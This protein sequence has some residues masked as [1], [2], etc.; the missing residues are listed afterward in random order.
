MKDEWSKVK[1]KEPEMMSKK[2]FI[3]ISLML[4]LGASLFGQHNEEVTIEGTYRPKVNKV[5]KILITPVAPKPSFSMPSTEV[6]PMEINHQFAV[7]LEK[8]PPLALHAKDAQNEHPTKNFLMV[9]LGTRISPVFL[10]KHHSKLTRDLALGVGIRHSSSWLGIKDYGPSGFMNNAFDISLT[11]SKFKNVQ[12]GGDV[13]YHNDLYHFYGFHPTTADM[14]ALADTTR[15]TYNTIGTHLGIAS[16]TTRLGE[17]SHNGDLDY[18]FLFDRFDGREHYAG[19]DYEL[20]YTQRWWGDKNYP[21][22]VGVRMDFKYA[23]FQGYLFEVQ[24][25]TVHNSLNRL[26]FQVNPYFEMKDEFYRLHL[27]FLADVENTKPLFGIYPDLKGSLFVLNKKV[28]FYAGLNGGKKFLTYSQLME[29]NPFL[30][31]EVS[32]IATPKV[33]LGFEAGIRTNV[34][35]TLDIHLGVRYRHTDNDM[36]F[37]SSNNTSSANPLGVN[38]CFDIVLDEARLLSVLANVRWLALDKLTL[39]AG[40]AYNNYTM[41]SLA[42]PWYRP[43]TEGSLKATYA[44]DDRLSMNAAFLYQGGRWGT[45]ALSSNQPVKLK[46]VFYLAL[47]ADYKIQDQLTVFAKLDNVAH[48]K[49][50]VFYE[51]PVAGI[52]FFAGVKMRF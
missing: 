42:H 14:A 34:M 30:G 2:Q 35:E 48:Q 20:G 15:Q 11:S 27:G 19:L 43:A 3:L 50:Q 41:K 9:G 21:Q 16:A 49:Y 39:D 36:F 52:Q 8:I 17:F 32:A 7:E 45:D 10:Y 51:Y 28:E 26:L 38:R 31:R 18:H 4:G 25:S 37:V 33:R 6:H 44:F 29:E 5:N 46:D 40:F 13:Y 1:F 47:G 22:K 23:N 12:L 24:N